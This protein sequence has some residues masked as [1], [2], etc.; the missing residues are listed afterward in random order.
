MYNAI[1]RLV[2]LVFLFVSP[3][4]A[5][6]SI[7]KP[8][9]KVESPVFSYGSVPQGTL[10]KHDFIVKNTGT[11]DLV[12][13]KAVAGCGC[14]AALPPSGPITP[15][16]SAPISVTFDTSGFEGDKEK[17]VQ[18]FSND[19]DNP[20]PTL[21]LKGHIDTALTIDPVRVSFGDLQ[22]GDYVEPKT[23]TV[24]VQEG[25]RGSIKEISTFSKDISVETKANT[26]KSAI[27]EIKLSPSLGAGELRDRVLVTLAYDDKRE[28]TFNVPVMASVKAG[29]AVQPSTL[30]AGVIEGNEPIVRTA[31]V[32]S[33]TKET[34]NIS[35]IKSDDPSVRTSFKPI[36]DG[37]IYVV[38]VSIDPKSVTKDLRAAVNIFT[39]SKDQPTLVLNVYGIIPPKQ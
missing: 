22:Q 6:D 18:V 10:V 9:I 29:I 4:S 36:K 24:Q 26:G 34:F 39:T 31:K 19:I 12:I 15:G 33:A 32:V 28:Q 25:V 21:T 2:A 11:M 1:G 35:S 16:Q 27:A 23:V 8:I 30:S 7:P 17:T 13:Q 38:T 14:T 3:A 5:E 37:K 20:Q